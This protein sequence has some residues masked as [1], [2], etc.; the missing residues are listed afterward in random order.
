LSGAIAGS[1]LYIINGMGHDLSSRFIV[2]ISNLILRN[3][4]RQSANQ[5]LK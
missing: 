3:A 1:E 2:P 4:K 5:A